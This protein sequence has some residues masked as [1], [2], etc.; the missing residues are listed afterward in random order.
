MAKAGENKLIFGDCLDVMLGADDRGRLYIPDG[1]VDLVYLDPPFNSK[2]NYNMIFGK[3]RDKQ[4]QMTAF[5]DTWQ[6]GGQGTQDV[7]EI[8]GAVG[9]PAHRVIKNIYNMLGECGL[10]A[11]LGYMAKRLDVVHSKMKDTASIYLHCDPTA[12]RYLGVVMDGIFGARNFQNQVAWKRTTG[13]SDGNRWG[14]VYDTILLYTKSQTWT[15][16][17]QYEPLSKASSQSAYRAKDDREDRFGPYMLDN[18][19]A[20]GTS[21]G[22]SGEPWRG[23]DPTEQGRHW[24]APLTGPYAK[25]IEDNI[26]PGYR[27]IQGV[28]NRL[29]ALLDAD[30]IVWSK[31]HTP[32]LKRYLQAVKGEKIN[33]FFADIPPESSHSKR[34]TGYP[35]QKPVRL[36]ERIIRASSNPGDLVFDPFCGCGTTIVA[37]EGLDRRWIGIDISAAAVRIVTARPEIQAAQ[38]DIHGIPKG[39]EGARRLARLNRLQYERWAISTVPGLAPNDRRNQE[40]FDGIGVFNEPIPDS[41]GKV[42]KQTVTAEVKSSKGGVTAAQR[43]HLKN[44]TSS[45]KSEL[46]I[47]I[48]LERDPATEKWCNQQGHYQMPGAAV[49]YPKF[50]VFSAEQY[51][52]GEKP[53]LP[54]RL[55]PLTGKPTQMQL[56]PS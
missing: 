15:W 52:A 33:D 2:A 3:G 40:G 27:N 7:L 30:M 16:N 20:A 13:R 28:H 34:R 39:M 6:W 35:T 22:E 24:S 25:W 21:Q 41:P 17:N 46:G 8:E 48:T 44:H 47:F 18:L 32:R 37:A 51:F 42:K 54:T 26:I 53:D 14:R 1:S 50:Q 56:S 55:D 43:S 10:M 36:L 5:T 38:Y 19:K 4:A 29:N 23:H 12:G 9:H 49:K 11:Y 45:N 31:N